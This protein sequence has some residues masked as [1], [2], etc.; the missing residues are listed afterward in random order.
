MTAQTRKDMGIVPLRRKEAAILARISDATN[1]YE[2][3]QNTIRVL[4]DALELTIDRLN[5]VT[6]YLEYPEQR[7]M[8]EDCITIAVQAL[9]LAKGES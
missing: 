6:P 4:V 7:R 3:K 5:K 8:T 1:A 2:H 9:A